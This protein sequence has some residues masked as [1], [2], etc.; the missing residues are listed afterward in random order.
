MRPEAVDDFSGECVHLDA[1]RDTEGYMHRDGYVAIRVFYV[2][3]DCLI[4]FDHPPT[5]GMVDGSTPGESS[6]RG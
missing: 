4:R 1:A 2:C 6:T 5:A 3:V